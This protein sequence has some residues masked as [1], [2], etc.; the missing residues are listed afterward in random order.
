MT[1]S[2]DHRVLVSTLLGVAAVSWLG[3]WLWERLGAGHAHG[4]GQSWDTASFL[5]FTAGWVLMT[6][7]MMLPTAIP[8]VAIF[9]RLT[10]RRKDGAW[11]TLLLV[12]GYMAVW[13]VFGAAAWAG[14][15]AVHRLVNALDWLTANAWAVSATVLLAAGVYQFTP[16]KYACLD[17]CRAPLG[18]ITRRW[19]GRGSREIQS[20]R[21]GLDHG[22][23]CVGCCWSLMLV[24]FA[25]GLGSVLWMLA[26]GVVMV[27]EKNLPG[28]RR[29]TTPV[30]IVLVVVGLTTTA[31]GYFGSL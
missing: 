24:M 2:R 8:L 15:L 5:L 30:G 23:W 28:G 29:L 27:I 16:W 14:D 9:R 21:V 18:F 6:S 31:Q 3:L 22:A 7:A 20:L 25:V 19:T 12:L 11:L 10:R 13:S 17:R 4:H 26:L 1:A